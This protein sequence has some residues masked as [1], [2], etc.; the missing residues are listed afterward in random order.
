MVVAL[1]SAWSPD[2]G[3]GERLSRGDATAG[4]RVA[5]AVA[6]AARTDDDGTCEEMCFGEEKDDDDEEEEATGRRSP[7]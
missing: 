5:V 7:G 6:V 2:G 4:G 1:H 3:G